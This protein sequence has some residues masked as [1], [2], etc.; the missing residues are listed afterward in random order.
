MS[1]SIM[2]AQG[3]TFLCK[4]GDY[5]KLIITKVKVVITD[6]SVNIGYYLYSTKLEYTNVSIFK[7]SCY[8]QV[9]L[10]ILNLA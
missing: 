5:R 10:L 4:N 1:V 9:S 8:I 7:F 6:P 2:E 3:L